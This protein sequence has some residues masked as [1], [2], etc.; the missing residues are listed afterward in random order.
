MEQ[1]MPS[2]EYSATRRHLMIAVPVGLI[3]ALM[4]LSGG[5]IRD[6][7]HT[8]HV[9]TVSTVRIENIEHN[10]AD[11][12]IRIQQAVTKDDLVIAIR[13]VEQRLDD[14]RDILLDERKARNPR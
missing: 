9:E 14:M 13:G 10:L 12:H 4:T 8:E 5:L 1:T 3:S 2:P 11:D 7:I 6:R